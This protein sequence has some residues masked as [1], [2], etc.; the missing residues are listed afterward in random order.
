M[1]CLPSNAYSSNESDIPFAG[2]EEEQEWK[3]TGTFVDCVNNKE[4]WHFDWVWLKC[5]Q[6]EMN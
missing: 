2:E 1:H 5:Q 4:V 3:H 6:Y